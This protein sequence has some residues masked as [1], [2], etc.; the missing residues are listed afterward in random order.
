MIKQPRL[1]KILANEL[2]KNKEEKKVITV[3]LDS[4][5]VDELNKITKGFKFLNPDNT[6]TRQSLIEIA[7]KN[8]IEEC[9][10]I[11]SDNGISEEVLV[12]SIESKSSL[13]ED[14]FDTVIIPVER[15]K[16]EEVIL[17]ENSLY[18]VRLGKDK[19]SNIKYVACYVAKDKKEPNTVSGVS[20]YAK[21]KRVEYNIETGK[22][23]IVF[24]GSMQQLQHILPLGNIS[25]AFVRSN[26]YVYLKDLQKAESYADLV[27]NNL[28]D[29]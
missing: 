22:Y 23:K 28:K 10:N 27:N 20:H 24:D 15:D 9:N 17:K 7:I 3:T 25:P 4:D 19:I 14:L 26:R 13:K 11:L 16:F 18:Y 1:N 29:S 12:S 21:V 5:S 2:N 6:F 8:L